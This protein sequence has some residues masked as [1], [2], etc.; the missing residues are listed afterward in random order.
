M[1]AKRV[2]VHVLTDRGTV[3]GVFSTYKE[4][5]AAQATHRLMC[6]GPQFTVSA[7]TVGEYVFDKEAR[8]AGIVIPQRI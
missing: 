3:L 2:R 8:E 1:E 5:E 4:A 6:E 7:V